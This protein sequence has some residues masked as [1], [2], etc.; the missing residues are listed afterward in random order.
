MSFDPVLNLSTLD[1][2]NG[3]V[4]NLDSALQLEVEKTTFPISLFPPTCLNNTD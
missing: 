3:F 2:S 1:G 4:I